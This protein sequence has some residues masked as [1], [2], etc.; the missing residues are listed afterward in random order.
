[1]ARR[2]RGL[3]PEDRQLWEQVAATATPLRP[4][5]AGP[6]PRPAARAAAGRPCPAC[7]RLPRPPEP[8]RITLDLAPDPHAALDRASP[9]MDRRRFE[10]LRRGRL[11]PEARHR[12]ARHDLGARPCGAD[13]L[14]PRRPRR[15]TCGCVLV[16]TG[17]GRRRRRRASARA[18]TASCAT[19]CRTGWPRRRWSAASC[20]SRPPT[21]ATAA[22]APSTSI[23][24]AAAD[25]CSPPSQGRGGG[26]GPSFF[27]IG[28]C[29][30]ELPTF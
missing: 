20:R 11:E 7:R 12:P 5:A 13:R 21:S 30:G 8:P 17:K 24:A 25:R 16:I 1:M 28:Q 27:P 29:R 2:R 14:H 4:H 9:Q 10:K 18:A 23:C 15:A 22:R 3:T 26:A 6:A 19:A